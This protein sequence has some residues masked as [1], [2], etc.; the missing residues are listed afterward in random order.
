MVFSDED[1]IKATLLYNLR[2]KRIIGNKHTHFDTLKSGFPSHQGKDVDKIAH[3]LIKKGYILTKPTNYG[4]QVSLNK[5][6]I[7]E[8]E[9]FIKK[10]LGLNF[11]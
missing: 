4:L 2:R 11:E 1:N 7:Q 3:E 6:K 10:V 8:I 9:L 5:E